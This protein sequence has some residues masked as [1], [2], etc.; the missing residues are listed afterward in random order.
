MNTSARASRETTTALT[1][2]LSKGLGSGACGG[3]RLPLQLQWDHIKSTSFVS[4]RCLLDT[5]SMPA[6]SRMYLELFLEAIYELPVRTVRSRYPGP[7]PQSAKVRQYRHVF[8]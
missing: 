7:T 1:H 3:D 6:R 4:I 2:L 5:S 8:P